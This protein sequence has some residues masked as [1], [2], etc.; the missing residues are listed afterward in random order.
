MSQT[1]TQSAAN[2]RRAAD[3][4]R[5]YGADL[6][7]ALTASRG[8]VHLETAVRNLWHARNREHL[9]STYADR[10]AFIAESLAAEIAELVASLMHLGDRQKIQALAEDEMFR[11]KG[12]LPCHREQCIAQYRPIVSAAIDR[13]IASR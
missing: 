4:C 10:Q 6:T 12:G 13:Q 8:D 11:R 2:D 3:I 9:R 1:Q 5:A 7:A